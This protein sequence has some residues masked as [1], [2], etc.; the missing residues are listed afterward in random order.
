MER[1]WTVSDLLGWVASYF[2]DKHIEEPR[3]EAEVLLAYCLHMSRIGLY[4]NFDRPVTAEERD[5]LKLL[6]KRRVAGEPMAYLTGQKEFMSL[7]FTVSPVVLIPRPETEVLVE[8][9][10]QIIRDHGFTQAADV[11]T[12]SGAIALSLVH[13]VPALRVWGVDI[14]PEAIAMAQL[15]AMQLGLTDQVQWEI[16]DLLGDLSGK[17]ELIAANLPYVPTTMQGQLPASV[18]DYEPG[19][20]LWAGEDGFDVYRRFIPQAMDRLVSGGCLLLEID[21]GQKALAAELL[22]AY[23][24]V[25]FINDLTG[26]SRVVEAWK[27]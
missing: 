6:L 25:S 3:L 2:K 11:G 20:A 4:T 5:G 19:L 14:S 7:M 10:I 26:R 18:S 1:V 17:F 16:N 9:A 27:E 21:P 15:N 23:T 8:R 24:G 13:Y 12:G 22:A